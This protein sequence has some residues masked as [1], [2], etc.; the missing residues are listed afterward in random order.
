MTN[1]TETVKIETI[2]KINGIVEGW[3]LLGQAEAVNIPNV[4][5]GWACA[6]IKNIEGQWTKNTVHWDFDDCKYHDDLEA[7]SYDWDNN[8]YVDD[9]DNEEIDIDEA[10]QL[11]AIAYAY[12]P[13]YIK[14]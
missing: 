9:S 14:R 5:N 6:S 10:N 12:I 3:I 1:T 13:D 11:I 4:Q 8:Y 2:G 7:D